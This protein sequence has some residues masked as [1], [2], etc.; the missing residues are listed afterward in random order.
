MPVRQHPA[1]LLPLACI[2]ALLAAVGAAADETDHSAHQGHGDGGHQMS[3]EDLATLREKI[4]LYRTLTDAQI[5]ASMGRMRDTSDYLSPAGVHKGIGVLALGHGY[6]DA[7]DA[8]FKGGFAATAAGQPTAVGLGMAMMTSAH[9]QQAVDDLEAAGATTI[10]V[11]PAEIGEPTNL[12]KQWNYIFGLDNRSAYLDVARV[13]TKARIIMAPTP[14]KSPVVTR[15]LTENLRGVSREPARE[16]VVVVAHGPTDD[17]ENQIELAALERH[18]N[19]IRASLGLAG[20]AAATLQDDAP[21]EVRAA[22]VQRLRERMAA[23]TA[24]GRRV[25]VAPILM[26]GGGYV[27]QKLRKDLDGLDFEMADVGL[28]QSPLF[29]LWVEETVAAAEPPGGR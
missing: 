28:A 14:T 19:G 7:G 22:N 12:T 24:A 1:R 3:A 18:A 8:Q 16:F 6:G 9:I 25:L 26:T 21:T 2:A 11:L 23:E 27:S 10:V 15:I 4:P 17:G 13:K 5:N 20:A 29:P